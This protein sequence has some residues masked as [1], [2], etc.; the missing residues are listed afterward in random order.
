MNPAMRTKGKSEAERLSGVVLDSLDQEGATGDLARQ[1]Y[2]SRSHFYRLF[3]ALVEESPGAMR[4]RLLLERAA[5]EL[6]RTQASVTEIAFRANYGSLEAFT[7]AFRKAFRVSP[8]LYRRM[9]ATHVRLPAPNGFHFCVTGS[10]SKGALHMDL[11]DRFAGADSWHSRRLLEHAQTLSEEQLDRPLNGTVAVFGW[12]QPDKNL[13]EM[14]E[15]IVQTKEVWTAALTGGDVPKL[16][17]VPAAERTP[18]A[19]LARFERA[20]AEFN[21]FLSDVRNREAWDDTFVDALCEPPETFT[22][23]GMFAHVITFN[24]YRRLTALDALRRL[25]VNVEGFGCPTEYE[26]SVAPWREEEAGQRR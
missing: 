2:R 18:A 20:D 19:L 16:E 11:F 1:A 6:G 25:G 15:R 12:C 5:W 26:T 10:R 4:R 14:L 9:G 13:R 17:G 23:G 8:S 22:F 7:R 24:T 21:R 3:R